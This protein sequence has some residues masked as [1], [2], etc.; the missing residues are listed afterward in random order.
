[1]CLEGAG[2]RPGVAPLLVHGIGW[3]SDADDVEAALQRSVR[4]FAVLGL[5][6]TRAGVFEV[7]GAADVGLPSEVAIGSYSGRSPCAPYSE[8]G[9]AK[10]DETC[11]K[12]TGACGLAIGS[13]DDAGGKDDVPDLDVGTACLSGDSLLIDVDGDGATES[14]PLATFIDTVR[15]PAEEVL[16]AP[17]VGPSCKASFAL[18]DLT[19]IPEPE[20]PK[21]PDD[22]RYHVVID[23]DGVVDLDGDGRR[24]VIV[25]FRYEEGRTLV[26]YSALQQAGRLELVGEAVPWQ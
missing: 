20:D 18:Y 6:G 23:I 25:S 14:F 8:D 3:S 22:P 19:I 12:A 26:I 7:L 17:V 15:A 9:G 1:M 10:A 13:I 2:G 11:V 5:D 24:E 16:A 21:A 4:A